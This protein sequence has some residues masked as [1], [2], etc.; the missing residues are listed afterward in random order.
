MTA[1]QTA[2]VR[3]FYAIYAPWAPPTPEPGYALTRLAVLPTHA[4]NEDVFFALD[5]LRPAVEQWIEQGYRRQRLFALAAPVEADEE[6]VYSQWDDVLNRWLP[7]VTAPYS[8]RP[9]PRQWTAQEIL[10]REARP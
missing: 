4:L 10:E 3:R 9:A 2:P 6:E 8:F 7:W 1:P 5:H